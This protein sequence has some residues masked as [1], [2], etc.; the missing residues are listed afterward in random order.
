MLCFRPPHPSLGLELDGAGV[1]LA[2]HVDSTFALESTYPDRVCTVFCEKGSQ[3][4]VRGHLESFFLLEFFY[5]MC[6]V[7]SNSV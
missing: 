4:S 2:M 3:G 1:L 7:R 5:R 6:S